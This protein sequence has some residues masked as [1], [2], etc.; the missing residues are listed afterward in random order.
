MDSPVAASPARRGARNL[1]LSGDGAGAGSSE[2]LTPTRDRTSS[3]ESQQGGGSVHDP[4]GSIREA[5]LRSLGFT[6]STPAAAAVRGLLTPN[7]YHHDG[8]STVSSIH[9]NIST[10]G[11]LG[12]LQP[13]MI[14]WGVV[15]ELSG[16][17]R[18]LE[19]YLTNEAARELLSAEPAHELCA[20]AL[21]TLPLVVEANCLA[22]TLGRPVVYSL[23]LHLDDEG[24]DAG[25]EPA[26]LEG[27]GARHLFSAAAHHPAAAAA[28]AAI[29]SNNIALESSLCTTLVG[30][31]SILNTW[32]NALAEAAAAVA[33]S[34]YGGGAHLTRDPRDWMLHLPPLVRHSHMRHRVVVSAISSIS[35]GCEMW[36]VRTFL[37]RLEALRAA[38]RQA[39]GNGMP[40]A[41]A[42]LHGTLGAAV[43]AVDPFWVTPE[44]KLLSKGACYLN[45]LVHSSNTNP[46]PQGGDGRW[47]D[48]RAG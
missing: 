9:T 37:R 23:D 39:I 47:D 45:Q 46:L 20:C 12:Y 3:S 18:D 10:L 36:G 40:F 1:P 11:E 19:R 7:Q 41:L 4:T 34:G 14:D 22:S 31:R 6:P 33:S 30:G 43:H 48:C 16:K 25:G 29:G 21:R 13:S 28:P 17:H 2:E 26:A 15:D 27:G 24:G 35:G 32:A 38:Y 8:A 5:A 42:K 44:P